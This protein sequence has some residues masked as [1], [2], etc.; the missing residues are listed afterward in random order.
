METGCKKFTLYHPVIA[1]KV[2]LT[3][4]NIKMAGLLIHG[5]FSKIHLTSKHGGDSES[6]CR[7][8][9]AMSL[10]KFN[11]FEILRTPKM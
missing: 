9:V 3:R 11:C 8:N 7:L 4:A 1:M 10:Q 5:K 6:K 2:V